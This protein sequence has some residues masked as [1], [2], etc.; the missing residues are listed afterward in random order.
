MPNRI[1]KESI[2]TSYEINGLSIEAEVTFYRLLTFADDYGR[3][4]SDPRVLQASL[5]P[6]RPDIR[7]KDF[8]RWV[9]EL[10]SAGLIRLYISEDYKPF[11]FFLKWDKHQNQRAKSSKYPDPVG[12]AYTS[13]NEQMKAIEDKK[14][15][16]NTDDITC[17]HVQ[18]NV[19]V[20]DTRTRISNLDTRERDAP[21]REG[22]GPPEGDD[23]QPPIMDQ[24]LQYA[25]VHTIPEKSAKE[26]YWH[27]D[28][29]GWENN[30][31][32]PIKNW[33]SLLNKW[34]S[35]EPQF[36]TRSKNHGKRDTPDPDKIKKQL[37]RLNYES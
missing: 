9:A 12:E 33:K 25:G 37:D 14:K 29:L 17:N 11:G 19:P 1:I 31:G 21:A 23:Y 7:S 16:V 5:F 10:V 30:H 28:S 13:I 34:N 3:F 6:L 4:P 15:H 36:E 27:Y 26:F 24:V 20:L 22:P 35:R 8:T 2:R 32:R 18:S